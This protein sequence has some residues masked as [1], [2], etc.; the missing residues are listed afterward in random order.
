MHAST[1]RAVVETPTPE[2]YARQLVSY[3]GRRPEWRTEGSTSTAT[4]GG[5]TA[6]VVAG[7][8][9]LELRA[10]GDAESVSRAERV[11]GNHLER[12]DRRSRLRVARDR[13]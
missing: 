9:V 2:R 11:L 13:S 12:F 1:S 3:L 4:I 6:H 5:V 7:D 8:G 10:C